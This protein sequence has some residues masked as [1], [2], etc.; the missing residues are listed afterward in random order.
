MRLG[1]LGEINGHDSVGFLVKFAEGQKSLAEGG[2]DARNMHH[3]SVSVCRRVSEG[4]H[5][6]EAL[7]DELIGK[8]P[9]KDT[10]PGA[11]TS[12]KESGTATPVANV[13]SLVCKMNIDMR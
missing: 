4:Y 12:K 7:Y 1:R 8:Y 10:E 9:T 2:E 5:V 3:A 11:T 6:S 13:D